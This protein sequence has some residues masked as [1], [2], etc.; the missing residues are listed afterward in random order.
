M[1][2][3]REGGEFI[4]AVFEPCDGTGAFLTDAAGFMDSRWLSIHHLVH[5]PVCELA[6]VHH[7]QIP[8]E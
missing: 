8:A 2:V 4:G 1:M 7:R 5:L 6:V 3:P